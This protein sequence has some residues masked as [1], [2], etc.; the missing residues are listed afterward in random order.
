MLT[1]C[2]IIILLLTHL[3][4]AERGHAQSHHE[5]KPE[6][7]NYYEE[8]MDIITN[9]GFTE[10]TFKWMRDSM[11]HWKKTDLHVAMIGESGAGKSAFIN[12]ALDLD[13]TDPRAA[14]VGVVETTREPAPY[15]LPDK[16]LTLWDLPGVGTASFP[17][18]TY[19]RQIKF[20][21]YEFF[22]IVSSTRFSENDLWLAKAIQ[23][24]NKKFYF[25]R[26]KIDIDIYNSRRQRVPS[27][28]VLRQVY[29]NCHE[30]LSRG[31]FANVPVFLISNYDPN[32]WDFQ[33]LMRQLINDVPEKKREALVLSIAATGEE[34][35]RAKRE[36]L[37]SRI[38]VAS[39]LASAGVLVPVPGTSIAAN[40]AVLLYEV[41]F[42]EE[43]FG[44]NQHLKSDLFFKGGCLRGT[45]LSSLATK[46]G[47][48]EL[49]KKIVIN[50]GPQTLFAEA[51]RWIPLAGTAVSAAI[52]FATTYHALHCIL[53]TF[54]QEALNNLMTKTAFHD[55]L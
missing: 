19:L 45:T 25:V 43:Q 10:A 17:K 22:I 11:D 48:T 2:Y 16:P 37:E 51:A 47:M 49:I 5:K 15:K 42:Y 35:I 38:W 8:M 40:F 28:E 29:E 52:T 36:A 6:G 14:K 30:T 33:K 1:F 54:E 9:K 46:K 20:R 50:K 44:L 24:E 7:F 53:D 41:S 21:R 55:E 34:A 3:S 18:E 39:G 31:G 12:A 23:Q 13:E 4:Q 32:D 26:S 27:E